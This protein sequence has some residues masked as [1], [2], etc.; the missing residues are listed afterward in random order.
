LREKGV[1][2][3]RADWTNSDPIITAELEKWKRS[4]VPFNLIYRPGQAPRVL[5]ELLNAGIVLKALED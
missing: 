1:V 4:A 3:L 2:L 5:P